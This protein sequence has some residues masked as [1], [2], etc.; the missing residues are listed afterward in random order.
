MG[1]QI[2]PQRMRESTRTAPPP[3]RRLRT[4]TPASRHRSRS[5]MV[6]RRGRMPKPTTTAGADGTHKRSTTALPVSASDRRASSRSSASRGASAG[7]LKDVSWRGS[8][9]SVVFPTYNERDSIRSAIL[10]FASTDVVDEILVIN[11]NAAPGTSDEVGTAA[12]AV[13][14]RTIVREVH[15]PRQ[16]Y[17]FAIRRGL[18]E[19]RGDYIVVSAPDGTFLGR[20]TL[21]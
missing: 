21:N 2:A 13:P 14:S 9:I 5:T 7:S 16:G 17:G 3:A 19:A 1:T 6:S 11:N 10:D 12:A 8:R 20:D 15:E 4:S 18:H